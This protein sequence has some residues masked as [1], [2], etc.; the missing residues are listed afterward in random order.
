MKMTRYPCYSLDFSWI[1]FMATSALE[2]I[3][4]LKLT[5]PDDVGEKAGSISWRARC[6]MWET[7]GNWAHMSHDKH[8]LLDAAR[9]C[10]K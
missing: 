8:L 5:N 4:A 7:V 9:G 1:I 10:L 6:D 2:R 3:K